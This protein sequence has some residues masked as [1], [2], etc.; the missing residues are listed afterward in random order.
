VSQPTRRVVN[1]YRGTQFIGTI[2]PLVLEEFGE[3]TL[4]LS[5][6]HAAFLRMQIGR[7][8]TPPA[9]GSVGPPPS[10]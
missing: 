2:Q 8:P 4:N 10:R 6:D 5:E 7:L 3:L 1:L 9:E